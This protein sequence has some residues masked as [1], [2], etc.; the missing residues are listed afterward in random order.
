MIAF[1]ATEFVFSDGWW[2]LM[3]LATA[4]WLENRRRR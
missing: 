4:G 1:E 3:L 2:L